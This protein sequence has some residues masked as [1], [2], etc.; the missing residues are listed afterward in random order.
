V[1]LGDRRLDMPGWLEPAMR[2]V[3]SSD[4]ITVRDLAPSLADPTSRIV[5]ARRLVR[6]GLLLVDPLRLDG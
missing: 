4:T 5:L 6:E 2:A 1:L 3:A